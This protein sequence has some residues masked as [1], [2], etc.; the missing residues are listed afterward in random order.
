MKT[1]LGR[2]CHTPVRGQV[3]YLEDTL[4]RVDTDGT[5][6][7]V[8]RP[9][10]DGYARALSEDSIDI[11]P[12]QAFVLPGFCD[13]H[14]HAP[15]WPQIGK[16][17]DL[18][19]ESWLQ[20]HT[21]PLEARYADLAFAR[22]AYTGLVDDL[23]S[24]GTTTALYF[25][26]IHLEATKL[27]A[28]I[29]LEKGQRALIGKVVMDNPDQCPDFYRDSSTYQALRD[30]SDFV[31]WVR[32][33]PDNHAARV[34][35]VVT[36]RFIPSC[37]D[38]ALEGL[39][40]IAKSCGC[41]VQTH[42]SESDWQ[43][44]YVLDRHGMSD[45][46]SLDRFGLL[47]RHTTLAHANF[48][49][50]NNMMTIVR[51]GAGV[52]HCPLSNAYFS[53]AVFP[54]R[55]ALDKGIRVGLGTDISGGP[56]SFLPDSLRAAVFASR[57]LDDGVD[58]LQDYASRGVRD[59]RIDWRTA[60]YLATKGGAEVLDLPVGAFEPGRQFDAVLIDPQAAEGSVRLME[61]IDNIEEGLQK[62][63]YTASK[64]NITRV[65][66]GG[67]VMN[68]RPVSSIAGST[69]HESWQ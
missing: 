58:A 22:A 20:H 1:Y 15:Q 4:I 34:R 53:T 8:L 50:D 21:F 27:L 69:R 66:V 43:H 25:A 45:T 26:T 24:N 17:L 19:L 33:H 9:T 55:R 10:D 28:D 12:K 62:I 52:A 56:S 6:Q 40:H 7:A 68:R 32:E 44:G 5:I 60:F 11:F 65:W 39:G 61:G 14:I 18:P 38:A 42:C 49:S 35:P 54:L 48:L 30:T 64:A 46:D 13:L 57:L 16:A 23:L 41:H 3:E 31:A 29:C 2:F 63:L 36:P 51:H 47:T 37:T 59:S 67:E